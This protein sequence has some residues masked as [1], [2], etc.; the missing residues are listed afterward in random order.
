MD[1]EDIAVPSGSLN[2]RLGL[3]DGGESVGKPTSGNGRKFGYGD[4]QCEAILGVSHREKPCPVP[5][6]APVLYNHPAV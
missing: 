3:V 4:P 1:D 2:N 6:V 5:R